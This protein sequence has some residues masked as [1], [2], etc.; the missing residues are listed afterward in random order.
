MPSVLEGIVVLDLTQVLAGPFAVSL[1]GDFGADVIQIEPPTGGFYQ[2]RNQTGFS[3][4]DNKRRS[5]SKRRHRK[6]LTLNL[7]KQEGKEIFLELVKKTDVVVQNFSPGTMD[8]LELGYETLKK[9]NPGI[10][11]CAISGFGQDGPYKD[12]LAYDPIIQAASGIMSVTGF[13][14]KPPVKVGINIADYVGAVYAII[15]ILLALYYKKRTGQGQMVDSSMF[16]ALCHF[17]LN[18]TKTGQMM[19]MER[20]GNRYPA[21][22]L[23]VHQTKDGEYI[24]FTAQTDAQWESFLKLIGKDQIVTEKWDTHTR[25]ILRRDEVEQWATEWIKNKTLD[26][27][28]RELSNA[29]LP[30]ATITKMPELEHDPHVLSRGLLVEVADNEFGILDGVRGVVPKLSETPGS[31]GV[32]NNVPELGQHSEEILKEMLGYTTERIARLKEAGVI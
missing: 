9:S 28:I 23:D 11:Y 13:P 5:W 21:A 16:D 20:F 22:I 10:I 29:A 3:D 12:R 6:S 31:V 7:R 8:R 2:N 25:N 24:L 14:D 30:C 15:G 27:I 1:L 32:A 19:G 26:E 4:A 18:E 17:T